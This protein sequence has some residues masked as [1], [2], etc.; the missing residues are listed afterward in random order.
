MIVRFQTWADK[1]VVSL[2]EVEAQR[3]SVAQRLTAHLQELGYE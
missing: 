2:G 1:Y 3:Q